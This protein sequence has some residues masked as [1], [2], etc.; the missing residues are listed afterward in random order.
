MKMFYGNTPIKS[1][2]V[3]HYEMST[4]DCDMIASDLQAGKTAVAKGQ[5]ITGTGKSFEFAYYG[6]LRT[7]FAQILPSDNINIVHISCLNYPIKFN[8]ALGNMKNLD[9]SIGQNIGNIIID[10][11]EYPLTATVANKR[12]TIACDQSLFIQI[13]YGKDNYV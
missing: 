7:N 9:F 5:K 6:Q 13:F 2:N 8:V 12:L 10:N 4:N 1:L 3:K 11:I